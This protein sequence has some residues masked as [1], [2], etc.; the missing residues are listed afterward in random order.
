[1]TDA[2]V[3]H[4]KEMKGLIHVDLNKTQLTDAGLKELTEALP[5][6]KVTR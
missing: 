3:T 1:M 5:N 6:C 4:L 2:G